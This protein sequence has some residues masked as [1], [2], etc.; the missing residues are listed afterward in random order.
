VDPI[1][2]R[3][4]FGVGVGAALGLNA[5]TAPASV[6]EID[7]Q[8]ASH[9]TQLLCVLSRHD[10]MFGPYEVL[11][12]ARHELD[13]IAQH[14]RVTRGALRMEFLRV[15]SWWSEFASWLSNDTGDVRNRDS[16]GDHALRLAQ[17]AEH[18][19]MVA[20]VLMRQSQWACNRPDPPRVIAFAEAARRTPRASRQIRALCALQEA[21]GHALA[22]DAASCERSI[23]HAHGLL[24]GAEEAHS[25][26][27]NLGRQEVSPAYVMAA[28][29]RCWV[30]LRPRKAIGLL[31]DALRAWPRERTRGRG[32][33][34]A[35][36]ALACAAA[37]QPD[38][39]ADEGITAL[40]IA[41]VTK[42]DLTMRELKRLDR[43]LA[44]CDAPAAADFHEAFAA[45]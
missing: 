7:P 11:D 8:L 10:A 31:E 19:D 15:E 23:G 24:A 5:T 16:W 34:Q 17:E 3:S 44:A 30:K 39:A 28:E 40:S 22:N 6:R 45:I 2:R 38:R 36:L 13:L 41:Q 42:S 14:R 21:Q 33:H 9:W 1:S 18:E 4:L 37:G 26:P 20:W 25:P 43:K 32:I 27:R 35:R 29:A 12:A